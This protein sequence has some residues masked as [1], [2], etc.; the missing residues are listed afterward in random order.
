MVFD[1]AFYHRARRS[2]S[3]APMTRTAEAAYGSRRLL[4]SLF[5]LSLLV[6]AIFLTPVL[7][8]GVPPLYDER[9][10]YQRAVAMA[11]VG[12]ASLT[13]VPPT[14]AE[15]DAAYAFGAWPPLHS[16]ILSLPLA[17][18]GEHVPVARLTVALLSALTTPLLFLLTSRLSTRR[19]GIW[20]AGAHILYPGFVGFA[21]LLWSETTFIAFLVGALYLA[22]LAASETTRPRR[23]LAALAGAALG[24]SLL[25]RAAGLPFL[26][27]VPA[28]LFFRTRR[29]PSMRLALPLL[30]AGTALAAITPWEVVLARREG[31]VVILSTAAGPNLLLG[32]NPWGSDEEG[33]PDVKYQVKRAIAAYAQEHLVSREVAAR[34]IA[35]EYIAT[36]PDEVPSRILSKLRALWGADTTILRHVLRAGYPPM[37]S[38]LAALIWAGLVIS[39]I[40]L[41]SFGAAGL[42]GDPERLSERGLIL[43]GI[44]A[45]LLPPLVTIS[46]TRMA[47]PALALLC[48][49]FGH[50]A[51]RV[52]R[53]MPRRPLLLAGAVAALLA[54]NIGTL[55]LSGQRPVGSSIYYAG[56]ISRVAAAFSWGA[57]FSDVIQLRRGEATEAGDIAIAIAGE[58]YAFEERGRRAEE[59]GGGGRVVTWRPDDQPTF[60]ATIV[61]RDAG[62]GR[63]SGAEALSITLAPARATGGSGDNPPAVTPIR[64]DAWRRWRPAGM[65]GVEFRWLGGTTAPSPG[66]ASAGAN[67]AH[68]E[69]EEGG[70]PGD[71]P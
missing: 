59:D 32:N 30:L 38:A 63:L 17:L 14:R 51:A 44:V 7:V 37:P 13:G 71:S 6:R 29:E 41:V 47:L 25:T 21:H 56:M 34:N 26:L 46:S 27:L 58:A 36:H 39:F 16:L 67:L 35:L 24:C 69:E 54:A 33:S 19:A 15:R 18:F 62:E 48:P 61:S 65:R 4:L 9:A 57:R 66:D 10:H 1:D 70:E 22:V 8:S 3:V 50:A 45:V 40:A 20:A 23:L 12:A 52:S 68:E 43:G 42:F 53:G 31:S 11:R 55:P 64:A 28:W 2:G 49:A 5:L 60:T